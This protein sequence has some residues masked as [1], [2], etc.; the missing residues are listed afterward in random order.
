MGL[1]KLK[2]ITITQFKHHGTQS[3]IDRIYSEREGRTDF[4]HDPDIREMNDDLGQMYQGKGS[5]S[6]VAMESAK[7]HDKDCLADE[8]LEGISVRLMENDEDESASRRAGEVTPEEEVR[9]NQYKHHQFVK[10]W[11]LLTDRDGKDEEWW[12]PNP[13]VLEKSDL[14]YLCEMCR[15][16]DFD[17]LLSERGLPGNQ[18]P[19]PTEIAVHA[20][21]KVLRE[22]DCAFCRLIRE[23][24]EV[25]SL[26]SSKDPA[27]FA[28]CE[29]RLR[30]MDE[31]PNYA[32]RLDVTLHDAN[33][34]VAIPRFIIQR[35]NGE[36]KLPL[37]GQKVQDKAAMH[38]L[39]TWLHTCEE[40]HPVSEFRYLKS[41]MTAIR[42][43][44]VEKACVVKLE[45][46]VRYACLSYVWGG[47]KQTLYAADTKDLFEE[48]GGLIG[49]NTVL[50]QTIADAME[51][52]KSIGLRYL[53]VDALCILQDSIDDK[54][55]IIADMGAIYHNATLCI[56]ASTNSNPSGGLPGVVNP[57]KTK[58]ILETV[59]G[60]ELAAAFH[61]PRKRLSDVDASTW[62][63][64][65]WTYQEQQL[66]RRSVYFTE[67][68]MCFIC[69]HSTIFE[70]TNPVSDL[71]YK[72]LPI[73]DK[74]SLFE[75]P[76][77]LWAK[78]GSD[79]TQSHFI[80][81]A[82]ETDDGIYTFRCEDPNNPDEASD[83]PAP[84][85]QF[86]PITNINPTGSVQVAGD[87]TW[88][89]YKK[90]VNAY[91]QR[92]L[93][94]GS[95]TIN[96]FK[97]M[98]EL[99]RQASN[100]KFW[101]GIPEF[102]F[103]QALLWHPSEP[104][105]RRE[106][107]GKTLFPSWTWAAW[108]GN[109]YYRG[110]GWY[111]G[112]YHGPASA[113]H[114]LKKVTPDEFIK[115]LETKNM[116]PGQLEA[117]KLQVR[118]ARFL[119]YPHNPWD[120]HHLESIHELG[121]EVQKD[122]SRNQHYYTHEA[123]PG[124]N[125]SYPIALPQ[126]AVLERSGVDGS[127]YFKAHTVP[128]RFCDMNTTPAIQEPGQEDFIQIGLNDEE[129]SA[130]IRPSWKRI[131]YHQGYRAGFLTLN[132]PFEDIDLSSHEDYFLAAM[133]RD[134]LPRIAP[135]REGWD[136]YWALDPVSIQRNIWFKDEW[137]DG[138]ENRAIPPP[139]DVEPE[140]GPKN[141]NGDA[142]WDEGR[143]DDRC[144]YEVY[145]V[146]LLKFVDGKFSERIGVGKINH[147]AFWHAGAGDNVV[148]LR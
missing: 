84:I 111:N 39:K 22:D 114:W 44:D 132:I 120:L 131:L 52:T 100:T 136:V 96:A 108:K 140:K 18:L 82:F 80:N 14:Q 40:T 55:T 63:S 143:F 88:N 62:N 115:W 71:G 123:Y 73:R 122:I 139:N 93:A 72:P 20:L 134:E 8:E 60:L 79:P 50:P 137:E 15:H 81:K 33:S 124:I 66:P 141:E 58:Q 19:G 86:H 138:A 144:I 26:L 91:T 31:G 117:T 12:I 4:I 13:P 147:H 83:E 101:Y 53:W 29:I 74:T 129:K 37:L 145:N 28:G 135:P 6:I 11:G 146:L 148:M 16:I 1:N 89:V 90:A 109:S 116:P 64:R 48:P 25:D 106:Q 127:L 104:L 30:V 36:E 97:G 9:W 56:V 24:V 128:V 113:V 77:D 2:T 125:F 142:L 70:D 7:G 67:S 32:L 35:V 76:S 105:K 130:N 49:A 119:F 51:V 54:A 61:D 121:W 94:W 41:K 68:E 57:R 43:I 103:D 126:Q 46:P 42:V 23:K 133:S 92:D 10:R 110:R 85:Y 99:I 98:E 112:I 69:P 21:E 87:T 38:Q 45:H 17:I 95:D 75:S 47:A 102:A 65:G 78:V 3:V 59:Q 107:D 27:T 118:D 5:K 34:R